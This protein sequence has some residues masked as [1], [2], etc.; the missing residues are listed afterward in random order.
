MAEVKY[1]NSKIYLSAILGI[2]NKSI[3][4]FVIGHSNNTVLVFKSLMSYTSNT[5]I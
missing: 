2:G 5:Q 3:V 1:N 4:S